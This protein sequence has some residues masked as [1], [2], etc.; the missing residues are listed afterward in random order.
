MPAPVTH[1][2]TRLCMDGLVA[3]QSRDGQPLGAWLGLGLVSRELPGRMSS[4]P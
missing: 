3:G 1:E 4:T 2:P